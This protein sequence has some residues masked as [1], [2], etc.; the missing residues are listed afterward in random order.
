VLRRMFETEIERTY[1]EGAE[2]YILSIFINC[3]EES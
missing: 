3:S 2:E 1:P